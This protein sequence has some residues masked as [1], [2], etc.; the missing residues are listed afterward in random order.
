MIKFPFTKEYNISYIDNLPYKLLSTI[1]E[2]NIDLELREIF[3]NGIRVYKS[4][5]YS[6]LILFGTIFEPVCYLWFADDLL[7]S[8]CYELENRYFEMFKEGIN[9]ELPDGLELKKGPLQDGN[10]L[11][12]YLDDIVEIFLQKLNENYILFKVSYYLR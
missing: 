4:Y 10:P 8:I 2:S 6:E 1:D 7:L 12:V 11:T 3:D 5:R 9:S